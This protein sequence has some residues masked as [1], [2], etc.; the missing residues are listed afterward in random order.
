MIHV[1]VLGAIHVGVLGAAGIAPRAMLRPASRR[2]DLVVE[3]VVARDRGGRRALPP[4][5][6][7]RAMTA[8]RLS[9]MFRST[10]MR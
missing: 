7:S 6:G 10:P 2:Q 3:A 8:R 4:S 5:S 1:G 9:S